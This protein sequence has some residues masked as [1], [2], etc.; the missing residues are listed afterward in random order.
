MRYLFFLLIS[1]VILANAQRDSILINKLKQLENVNKETVEL[2]KKAEKLEK[3][4][5][6]LLK[7]LQRYIQKW[8]D[9]N[10]A[11]EKSDSKKHVDNKAV[12]ADNKNT[13]VTEIEERVFCDSIKG[14][15]IYR[16]FHKEDY[17]LKRYKI[18]DNEKIYLD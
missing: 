15:W 11:E 7:K 5:E 9:S 8:K 6:T 13:V 4:K 12:K 3:E 1:G 16:L 14:S 18:V 17:K 10:F 2:I